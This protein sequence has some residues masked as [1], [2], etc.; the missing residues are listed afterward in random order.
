MI[1]DVYLESNTAL[2]IE[3]KGTKMTRGKVPP[4]IGFIM[5]FIAA[6]SKVPPKT[7]KAKGEAIVPKSLI[8]LK[9]KTQSLSKEK[10]ISPLALTGIA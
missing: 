2:P 1:I 6:K 8:A 10:A 7:I 3:I 4:K 9:K 5:P